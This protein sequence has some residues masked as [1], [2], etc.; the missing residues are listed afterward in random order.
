MTPPAPDGGPDPLLERCREALG[1]GAADV[2]VFVPGRIELFGK[3]TDY[4][5]GTSIVL[6]TRQ[7]FRMAAR[8]RS[9][10]SIRIIP[11]ARPAGERIFE[12]GDRP[13]LPPGDWLNYPATTTRRLA[14]NFRGCADLPGVDLAF[15][16]DLPIAA[17][18]S[19]S[20][21]LMVATFLVLARLWALEETA[22]WRENLSNPE[23][24]AA[25][26]GCIE[27]GESFGRLEGESGV[28]TFGGSED[29]AAMLMSRP[30]HLLVCSFAPL[31]LLERIPWPAG[32][33][34]VAAASGVAAEKTGAKREEYN[35]AS[36]RAR[37]AVE[38]W[39]AEHGDARRHLADL[40]TGRD[41]AGGEEVAAFFTRRE[42]DT[43]EEAGLDLAGRVRQFAREELN[44][45][46]A[47][48][49]ALHAGDLHALGP[50]AD[51]SHAAAGEGLGTL[52][53]ETDRLQVLARALGAAAA[54]YF[55]AGFG[56]SVWALVPEPESEQFARR[57]LE[58]YTHDFPER[59]GGAATLITRPGPP[60]RVDAGG[61]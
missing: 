58:A 37:R 51:R 16:S 38:I 24:L 1:T 11:V 22:P 27:N 7:G 39:N 21:A 55:G 19:S 28:G 42:R 53:P 48:R 4:A 52:I 56:G 44:F 49:A 13:E 59:T 9:D 40:V 32:W 54:S 33:T 46:P 23:D 12:P 31:R 17:G 2:T 36:H 3:H 35:R 30:E 34:L 50:L 57:W 25:Y 60:A 26:L 41:E 47:A 18:M 45:T 6:A 14:L 29:H 43:G 61:N 10:S 15:A 20:S 8:S 5:G